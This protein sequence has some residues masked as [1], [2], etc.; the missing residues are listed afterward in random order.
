ML[1]ERIVHVGVIVY[2]M[3]SWSWYRRLTESGFYNGS[4]CRVNTKGTQ[5]ILCCGSQT[6]R[7]LD[8]DGT[9]DPY[10]KAFVKAAPAMSRKNA[11]HMILFLTPSTQHFLQ[12]HFT[13]AIILSL[14]SQHGPSSSTSHYLML[15][16]LIHSFHI[17]LQSRSLALSAFFHCQTSHILVRITCSSVSSLP[18]SHIW[19]TIVGLSPSIIA[20]IDIH[21]L[22]SGSKEITTQASLIPNF[23]LCCLFLLVPFQCF[24][25]IP[26]HCR[27]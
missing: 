11:W 3:R 15:F 6:T 12:E 14:V 25:F 1:A 26:F 16:Q 10:S 20:H 27:I 9:G 23:L 18:I 13:A 24:L 4:S 17:P 19:H 2:I 21:T 5:I 8:L 22:S 7:D